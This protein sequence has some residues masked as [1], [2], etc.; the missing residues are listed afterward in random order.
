MAI[1]WFPGPCW[2]TSN[3]ISLEVKDSK[4]VFTPYLAHLLESMDLNQM[5]TGV[6]Q[7]FISIKQLNSIVIS[8]PSYDKQVELSNWFNLLKENQKLIQGLLLEFSK[9]LE[10]FTENSIL[11]K[12]LKF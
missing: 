2:L 6:A 1:Q 5:A 11:E 7:K 4:T 8:L 12:T 9:D 3:A 10:L